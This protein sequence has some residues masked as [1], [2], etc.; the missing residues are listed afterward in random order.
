MN[1][2]LDNYKKTFKPFEGFRFIDLFSGIGGFHQA[3]SDLGAECLLASDIDKHANITYEIN[4][5]LKPEGD[6]TKIKSR[7]IPKHDIL[8][9]GFPCQSFSVAGKRDGFD[10][11]TGTLFL[12]IARIASY[13]QP[14]FLLLENVRNLISHDKGNTLRIIIEVLD[15]IGYNI[16]YDILNASDYGLPQKR[17]RIFLVCF[18]KDFYSGVFH[19][20][21]PK[22][23]DVCIRDIADVNPPYEEEDLIETRHG[24]E[25]LID[26]PLDPLPNIPYRLAIL[27][28]G[29]KRGKQGYRIY[30]SYGHAVALTHD[31]GGWGRQTGLYLIDGIVRRL[32]VRESVR[33][34]GFP[35]DFK[36]VCPKSHAYGQLG[37]AVAVNVAKAIFL[38]I[39]ITLKKGEK[40]VRRKLDT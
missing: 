33:L 6:I 15:E 9:A 38:K 39:F 12:D 34:Q 7:D 14:A 32:S 26:E 21:K 5:G 40:N 19:F 30:S 2:L 3:L 8:C 13:H 23:I 17:H 22:D 10:G 31:G 27:G 18:R 20:P 16:H 36:F 28:E 11:I 29:A 25:N 24:I 37:N 35:E 1:S 4:H